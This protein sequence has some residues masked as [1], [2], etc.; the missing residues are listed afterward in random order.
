MNVKISPI[1]ENRIRV[2]LSSMNDLNNIALLVVYFV[3]SLFQ[4]FLVSFNFLFER[5]LVMR[6]VFH[7]KIFNT[8]NLG[9]ISSVNGSNTCKTNDSVNVQKKLTLQLDY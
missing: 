2:D 6:L 8:S 4:Q 5:W 9:E 3:H 1:E 7:I